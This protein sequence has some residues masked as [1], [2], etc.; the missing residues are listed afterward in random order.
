M[1]VAPI[2][3]PIS[4]RRTNGSGIADRSDN[5][6]CSSRIVNAHAE[7]MKVPRSAASIRY[8]GKWLIRSFIALC[9][10]LRSDLWPLRTRT[11][12]LLGCAGG[13]IS[14]ALDLFGAFSRRQRLFALVSY[15]LL[16]RRLAQSAGLQI[17]RRHFS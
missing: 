8:S 9:L 17:G 2:A 16:L 6:G 10:S 14:V 12:H 1:A 5:A 15:R 11:F 4:T 7:I 13:G 3:R